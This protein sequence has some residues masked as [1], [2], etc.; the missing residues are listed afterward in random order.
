MG[1]IGNGIALEGHTR[2]YLGTFLVFSDYM[3]PAVRMAALMGLPPVYVWTHD[4]IGVGEDGPTHQPIEHLAA[5]RAIPNLSVVRPGDA[6]E[7]V[8]AWRAGARAPE[9]TRGS[10]PHPAEPSGP[11]RHRRTGR[12]R[13][14]RAAATSCVDT[15][16]RQPRTCAHRHR[17][18]GPACG[19]GSRDAGRGRESR[20]GSSRCPAWSGSTSS[21]HDYRD[22][23]LPPRSARAWLSRPASPLTWWRLVGD[24]GESSASTTTE[25]RPTRPRSS[26]SSAFT[27]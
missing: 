22:S 13:R 21:P 17:L 5:L 6:N 16:R 25:P 26:G 11:G 8:A 24:A 20:H 10:G 7:T 3:R 2:P 12:R 1:A 23:V 19:R 27:A 4:S 18:R 15:R 14:R 9:R